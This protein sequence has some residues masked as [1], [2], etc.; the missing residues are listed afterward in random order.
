MYKMVTIR[1]KKTNPKKRIKL[2]L[3]KTNRKSTSESMSLQ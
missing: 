2:T 1:K 3:K